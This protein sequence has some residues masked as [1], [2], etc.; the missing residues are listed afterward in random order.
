MNSMFALDK[1]SHF[2][3]MELLNDAYKSQLTD[4]LVSSD[5]YSSIRE[6][7]TSFEDEDGN[8]DYSEVSNVGM[9][10][11]YIHDRGKKVKKLQT[12]KDY[13]RDLLSLLS[14]AHTMG[15]Q[16]IREFS[17]SDMELFQSHLEQ[18]YAKTNT[19]A[20]KVVIVRSFLSWCFTEEYLKKNIARGLT[21]VIKNKSEIPERDIDEPV[22]K[23]AILYYENNPK[24]QSL[25]LTLTTTGIRL[26][27]ICSPNWGD[28]YYDSR[29]KKHYL[30][31][32]T[33]GD[34][35]RHVHIKDY[36][37]QVLI[38][39]RK[40]VGLSTELN[41]NDT[42][43]FYP[44]ARGRRYSVSSLSTYL[45]NKMEAAGL[46]SIRGATITPHY[47]RHYFAQTAFANGAPLEFIAETLGHSTSK[48]T[49]E[50]YL[51]RQLNKARDVSD[52]VDINLFSGKPS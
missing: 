25:L 36:A 19:L 41:P 39:Y 9:I 17:R 51:S 6:R 4:I 13:I 42:T 31:T 22:L 45:S 23:Q 50:N 18:R 52:H 10:Y 20:K 37:L 1:S 44:N 5:Y 46:I 33:K 16:D 26:N 34:K 30:F 40:R 14:Y 48:I 21:P 3:Q 7:V 15:K 32:R 11:M 47:L 2:N 35:T 43:P 49:K 27:E 38:E 12:K 29:F 8:Y 24:V 28:L